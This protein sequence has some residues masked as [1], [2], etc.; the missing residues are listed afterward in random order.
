MYS[1]VNS[2]VEFV[3]STSKVNYTP[4]HFNKF[5]VLYMSATLIPY[6]TSHAIYIKL[7]SIVNN[8]ALSFLIYSKALMAFK[9]IPCF[10]MALSLCLVATYRYVFCVHAST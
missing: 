1:V 6:C 4:L 5:E 10:V 3:I 8:C 7:I 9:Q 2:L